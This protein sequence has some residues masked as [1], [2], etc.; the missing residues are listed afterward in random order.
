[1][2]KPSANFHPSYASLV[3]ASALSL[4]T[5]LSA[6]THAQQPSKEFADTL[7]AELDRGEYFPH[8]PQES[9]WLDGGK[10]YTVLEP[11]ADNAGATDLVAY[12]T[13][14]GSR[15]ILIS[16]KDLIPAGAKDPLGI[17]DYAWSADG[18]QILIFTDAQKVWRLNT[19]GNYWVL[20][21]ADKKLSRIGK[22]APDKTLMFA[23][24]S[25]DGRSVAYVSQNNIYA[26][27]PADGAVRQLTSDGS[28]EIINGT[29]DWVTE[30]ELSLR[31]AFRW[32]PD[33]KS[34]AYWQ[35]DQSGVQEYS[36]INDTK[37]EYPE[38]FHYKYPHPGGTNA[39]VKVGVVQAAGGKTLWINLPGDPRNHYIP[40]M[41]WLPYSNSGPSG[42][43]ADT[44]E[45]GGLILQYLNRLQNDNQV[46]VADT[47]MGTVQMIFEDKDPAFV[48][49]VDKF[50]WLSGKCTTCQLPHPKLDF[51]WLSERD[52]WRHAYRVSLFGG[53]ARLIT[54]FEGDVIDEVS[55]DEEGGWFYF[56]ASPTNPTQ[57]YLYRSPLYGTGTPE[58][59]T[60]QDQP[61]TNTYDI[62][63]DGHWALHSW[64]SSTH[65]PSFDVIDL[66]TGKS[67]RTAIENNA[68]IAKENAINATPVEFTD[69]T[70]TGADGKP[71]QLSTYIV[72]PPNFDPTKKYPMLVNVYSE[73]AMVMVTDT[74][75]F[76]FDKV[77]AREGYVIVSFD[78][79]GTPAP[80]GRDWRKCIYGDIGVLSTTQQDQ[81]IVEFAKQHP[82]IDT[83]RVGMWGHSGGGSATLNE[84]FRHPGRLAAGVAIAP[85]AD[86]KLYD[87]IYQE[88]YMGLPADN[89]K[90]YHDG[91]PITFAD[92]LADPLLIIHGSGDD[93]V[94]F[95][96][97]ELLVDKLIAAGKP[98]DFMDYPN[99]THGLY[100]GQGTLAHRFLL[101]MRFFEEHVPPGPK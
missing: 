34:I 31:D 48:D 79:Q 54:N 96:G 69:T 86:Q 55:V 60:P 22:A 35:F 88:R 5:Y 3:L 20:R 61:G 66:H 40:R 74:W 10:R 58:R 19:R 65:P 32:S 87:T 42:K 15:S 97:T 26:E 24:F 9:R 71:I 4:G 29:T 95:Q 90:G 63:P 100:E 46:Y 98:F 12:D 99:R 8:Y 68:L 84:L 67:L 43:S 47:R 75:Q 25:P 56:I 28:Y 91:S 92:S 59:I 94:H 23:K 36:L 52:G 81:A 76:T 93:N 72:K 73:P 30:E 1:M 6:Q 13:A 64:S 53:Q 33:S 16:A 101:M 62:S 44:D 27:T 83:A 45:T 17:D 37:A 38:V 51:L 39:S 41:E 2:L 89:A 18:S 7:H 80:R 85:M 77:I 78:N 49:I 14:S 57:R 11:A 50:E 70:V 82:W 21:L